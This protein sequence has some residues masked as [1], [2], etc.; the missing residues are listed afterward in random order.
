MSGR[1]LALA[2]TFRGATAQDIPAVVAIEREAFSDPWNAGSF[3]ELVERPEIV[4]AVAVADREAVPVGE[5]A[6]TEGSVDSAQSV[7]GFAIIYLADF[8]GDL[9]NLA[10]SGSVH[11]RGVGRRL[12]HHVLGVARSRGGRIIFLEVRES[13]VAARALY[14]STGF[15]EVGRRSK[16]YVRPV[17]DALILR[18]EL[19]DMPSHA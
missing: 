9:A 13:N 16:Y 1:P 17:E 11:R 15:M 6:G 18:R 8:E 10:T 19:D 2:V 4:F 7:V 5:S 12:L 14:E 3:R